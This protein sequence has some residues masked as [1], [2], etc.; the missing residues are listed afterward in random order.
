MSQMVEWG[1]LS[2]PIIPKGDRYK[3][4]VKAYREMFGG[5][6]KLIHK[7][8]E[9]QAVAMMEKA[10]EDEEPLPEAFNLGM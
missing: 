5:E 1:A 7:L 3:V 4:A 6:P 10:L 2:E 9:S 8:P